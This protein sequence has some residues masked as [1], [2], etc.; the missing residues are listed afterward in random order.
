[1]AKLSPSLDA[2]VTSIGKVGRGSHQSQLDPQTL[3]ALQRFGMFLLKEGKSEGT[4]RVYRSLCAKAAAQ[5]VDPE[6]PMMLSAL[7]ALARFSASR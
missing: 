5:G 1:M 7:R 4:A 2:L 3:A 6:N